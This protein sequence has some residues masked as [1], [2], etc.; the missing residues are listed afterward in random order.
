M[1][2]GETIVKD[3][4]NR[5]VIVTGGARGMG[6]RHVRGFV[7]EGANVVIADVLEQE[8]RMLADELG[9]HAIFSCLDITSVAAGMHKDPFASHTRGR[10]RW[11]RLA[12]HIGA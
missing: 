8:G 6:A 12:D 7:A 1:F 10:K 2:E 4:D 9:D 11:F 5:T 3:L